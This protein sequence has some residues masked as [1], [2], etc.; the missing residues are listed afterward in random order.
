MSINYKL[1]KPDH[2]DKA[3]WPEC[4]YDAKTAVR[5]LRKNA[6]RLQID[7]DRIGVMGG[8]A[9][10]NL[11]AM[12]TTTVPK[13]GFEP[14]EPYG[15]FPTTVRCAIDFYGAVKLLDY[16]DM[17]MFAKTRA[18]APQL[19]EQASP[20]N[21]VT[22]NSAPMLIVHGS[23][24]ETVPLS[25]SEALAAVFKKAGAECKLVIIPDAPHTFNLQPKQRDLRGLVF[26]FLE[27]HL[28]AASLTMK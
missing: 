16:H 26:D 3:T 7:P 21:Y 2:R 20:V 17:K 28:K 18:D 9:G 22:K 24:D 14:E 15:E 11:S 25:Q 19:Y 8:S 12:L 23:K 6:D 10:G 13:D 5:W 27:Q 1:S 4:V